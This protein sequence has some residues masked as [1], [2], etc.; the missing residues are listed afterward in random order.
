[1]VRT[2]TRYARRYLR[3][4]GK[5]P[6]TLTPSAL[7]A[8]AGYGVV[9]GSLL[10]GYRAVVVERFHPAQTLATIAA[11]RVNV[12]SA[13]PTMYAMMLSL[14]T[15]EQYDTSSLLY[16]A[17][18]A[19]PCPPPLVREV[20]ERFG[21]P[22]MIAF[23][24]TELSG[25]PLVTQIT[26]PDE[27]QLESV[28]RVFGEAEIKVVDDERRELPPGQVG[29]LACHMDSIMK[30]YYNAPEATAQVVDDQGWYYTGDLAVIDPRGYVRIVGRKKDMIIRGGQNIF[31]LEVETF[32]QA[33]PKVQLAAVVGVPDPL[34]GESVWAFVVPKPDT[35][36]APQEVLDHCRGK[37]APYKVPQEVRVVQELPLTPT[38]KVQKFRLREAA[39][40]ELEARG[41][42]LP[43]KEFVVGAGR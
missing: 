12:L 14:P 42:A 22:V 2:V 39:I 10:S 20:R 41:V 11:E 15:F 25:A 24:A 36:L 43:G 18:T 1:M 37:I 29:E 17:M 27:M 30:G 19:A 5:P 35:P 28:G 38:A 3:W 4:S 23:G 9:L 40:A 26:D 21:C 6:T 32:L 13:T 16:C 8:L 34:G 31:P 33:H 7:H